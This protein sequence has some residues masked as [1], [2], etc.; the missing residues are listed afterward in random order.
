MNTTIVI[1]AVVIA[2][3]FL[4]YFT[5]TRTY[6]FSAVKMQ[7]TQNG[8]PLSNVAVIRRYDWNSLKED[9]TVTDEQGFFSFPA[10]VEYSITRLMPIELVISQ[11][12]YAVIDGEEVEF[13]VNA[14]RDSE[15][16]SEFFN[17][18]LN[19]QVTLT[20][21]LAAED[22]LS[23]EFGAVTSVTMTRCTFK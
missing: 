19:R 22:K 23:R 20:C 12:L 16:G 7:L 6:V 5:A 21:D 14:K 3:S 1:I 2:L 4:G 9:R 15:E 11:A 10:I 13:W 17:R 18:T 8:E